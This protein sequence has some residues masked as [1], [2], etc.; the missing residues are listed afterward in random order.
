MALQQ[1]LK[2]DAI[3]LMIPEPEET[4]QTTAD[5]LAA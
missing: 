4:K 1:A 5:N 2:I 3:P